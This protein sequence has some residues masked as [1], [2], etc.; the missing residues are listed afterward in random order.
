LGFIAAAFVVGE[1]AAIVRASTK[2]ATFLASLGGVAA[3]YLCGALW[4]AAW[5]GVARQLART[6]CLTQA[7]KLGVVPFIA[8]DVAKALVVAAVMESGRQWVELLQGI[9]HG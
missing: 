4:L 9:R 7:W 8:I 1:L 3:I 2:G 5:L 6:A